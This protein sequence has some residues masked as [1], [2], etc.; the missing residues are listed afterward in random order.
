MAFRGF[1]RAVRMIFFSLLSFSPFCLQ[2]EHGRS[3]YH[4]S[5]FF[6]P[7]LS[8]LFVAV[9]TRRSRLVCLVTSFSHSPSLFM[10]MLKRSGTGFLLITHTLSTDF[11]IPLLLSY[12]HAVSGD[13]RVIPFSQSVLSCPCTPRLFPRLPISL[14]LTCI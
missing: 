7:A 10:F 9:V 2:L 1:S 4:C 13:F 5:F 11:S 8:L 6:S 14:S 3:S 12:P